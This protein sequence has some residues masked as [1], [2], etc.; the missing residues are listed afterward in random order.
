MQQSDYAAVQAYFQT[1]ADFYDDVE[2]QVYW[3]LSDTLLWDYLQSRVL[4]A[5]PNKFALLDAGCGTGRWGLKILEAVP[6]ATGTFIDISP[7]M[8]AVLQRKLAVKNDTRVRVTIEQDN[9]LSDTCAHRNAFDLIICFHNVLGFIDDLDGLLRRFHHMATANGRVAV[10][11]PNLHHAVHFALSRGDLQEAERIALTKYGRFV[12]EMP[13][14]RFFKVGELR[15]AAVHSGFCVDQ[16][17]GFPNC[18]YP[19]FADTRLH[20]SSA[21]HETLMG[22]PERFQKILSIERKLIE[23]D[24]AARG[25]NLLLSLTKF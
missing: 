5:L 7:E 17:I 12:P 14:I 1:K 21:E 10:L 8:L 9:L 19:H 16:I 24:C 11:A 18:L 22:S 23:E 3:R 4:A 15:Q 13:P 2:H 25:A 6:A 20:G